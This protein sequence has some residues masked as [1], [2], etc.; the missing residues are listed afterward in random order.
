M[1]SILFL[2]SIASSASLMATLPT[3]TANSVTMTQDQASRLVTISYTL[4]D[5]PAIV[6]VD[7]QTNGV[8]IGAEK[9]QYVGGDVNMKVQP[10]THQITWQPMVEWPSAPHRLIASGVKAVVKAWACDDPPP[11]LVVDLAI[12]N[13]YRFYPCV[14][15]IPG[16]LTNDVSYKMDKMVMRRIPAKN[17]T[18]R[19]GSPSTEPGNA[20]FPQ[21]SETP[22]YV[23]LTND[24]YMCVFEVTQK[25]MSHFIPGNVDFMAAV[26]AGH[27]GDTRPMINLTIFDIRGVT[28]WGVTGSSNEM[29]DNLDEASANSPIAILRSNTGLA[30]NLPTDAQWEYAC[31][32]GTSTGV[33]NG[34]ES[35]SFSTYDD[36]AW[37]NG[38]T[39]SNMVVGLKQPN[40]WGLYD[41]LGNVE[42]YV[43]DKYLGPTNK[44]DTVGAA[45]YVASFGEGY[46]PGDVVVEPRIGFGTYGERTISNVNT[47]KQVYRGSCWK[48]TASTRMRSGGRCVSEDQN[49]PTVHRSV[50]RGFRLVCPTRF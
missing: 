49:S 19:M 42:E 22:H 47:C 15:A 10:G 37:H 1:K 43:L 18:W 39:T 27:E 29:P 7:I 26:W 50:H 35:G 3:I 38:N 28:K 23:R 24:Y 45:A 9:F 11:Y 21:G 12:N 16:G 8:S 6:T 2:A 48:W 14:E 4:Q 30:F 34:C 41:M 31:R 40:N 20:N 33:N 5:A 13:A 36:I 32:A 44:T 25:Q 46:Q 17:V